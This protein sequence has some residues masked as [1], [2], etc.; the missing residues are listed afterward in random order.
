MREMI[1]ARTYSFHPED[2]DGA[3]VDFCQTVRLHVTVS[4]LYPCEL[5]TEVPKA[6]SGGHCKDSQRVPS[7]P[8]GVGSGIIMS[9]LTPCT[10]QHMQWVAVGLHQTFHL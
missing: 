1:D 5:P 4:T 9:V 10:R 7:A 3:S 8:D 6:V 2:K